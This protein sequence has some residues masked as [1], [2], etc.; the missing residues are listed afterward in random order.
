MIEIVHNDKIETKDMPNLVGLIKEIYEIIYNLKNKQA[1]VQRSELC[2]KTLKTSLHILV[3]ECIL[4]IKDENKP[5]FLEQMDKL[6]DSNV[7]LLSY[8]KL[9]KPAS[10]FSFLFGK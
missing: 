2:G 3:G 4:K 9:L 5:E 10:W 1:A 8:P 7:S 6:I